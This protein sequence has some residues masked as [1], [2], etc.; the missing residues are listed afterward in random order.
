MI[1]FHIFKPSNHFYKNRGSQYHMYHQKSHNY[2]DIDLSLFELYFY[3]PQTDQHQYLFNVRVLM[4]YSTMG[5]K[6]NISFAIFAK[7]RVKRT[8]TAKIAFKIAGT[9]V[10]TLC[11]ISQTICVTIVISSTFSYTG[12]LFSKTVIFTGNGR[13]EKVTVSFFLR[14]FPTLKMLKNC[15]SFPFNLI[16]PDTPD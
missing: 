11:K 5:F 13:F 12:Y 1:C 14:H 15:V 16:R 2:Q 10:Q 9:M 7:W 3:N 6:S 8:R 4:V